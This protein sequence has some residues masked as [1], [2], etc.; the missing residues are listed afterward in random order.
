[1]NGVDFV[2]AADRP[3]WVRAGFVEVGSLLDLGHW[4]A[5]G[6]AKGL[7]GNITEDFQLGCSVDPAQ[8]T[9]DFLHHRIFD[10]VL[11]A[12]GAL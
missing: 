4:E 1:M 2:D 6:G 11:A 8:D 12:I 3:P 10:Q 7:L 5:E 9:I